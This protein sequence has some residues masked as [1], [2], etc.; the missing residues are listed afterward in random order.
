MDLWREEGGGGG[1]RDTKK[2]IS[3]GVSGEK[4]K[5]R[6]RWRSMEQRER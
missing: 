5:G 2:K 6:K 4:S 3:E 1:E